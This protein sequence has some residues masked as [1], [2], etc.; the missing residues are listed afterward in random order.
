MKKWLLLKFKQM[1]CQDLYDEI[2]QNTRMIEAIA[3]DRDRIKSTLR[4]LE[5]IIDTERG[6]EIY[7]HISDSM[8]RR[9]ADTIANYCL[10]ELGEDGADF[11]NDFLIHVIDTVF[12][13]YEGLPYGRQVAMIVGSLERLMT[14]ETRFN[15]SGFTDA[16][17]IHRSVHIKSQ[18]FNVIHNI[19]NQAFN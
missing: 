13:K 9:A 3:I 17:E 10:S 4:T 2:E 19:A 7:G 14:V 6:K 12:R 8:N 16:T 11:D 15:P 5:K 1:F 18:R